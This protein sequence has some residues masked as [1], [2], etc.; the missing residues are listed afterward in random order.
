[1]SYYCL[2]TGYRYAW[3]LCNRTP[4][5]IHDIVYATVRTSICISTPRVD[6]HAVL[7]DA[8]GVVTALGTSCTIDTC[9]YTLSV[10]YHDSTMLCIDADQHHGHVLN[11]DIGQVWHSTADTHSNE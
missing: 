1:M 9:S 11:Q 5:A 10:W 2:H 4:T 6:T 8:H 3:H 7:H